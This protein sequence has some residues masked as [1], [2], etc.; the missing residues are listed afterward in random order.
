M[1]TQIQIRRDTTAGWAD[2][3][4]ILAEGELGLDTD[5]NTIKIGNGTASWSELAFYTASG[6]IVP[7]PDFLTYGQGRSHLATLNTNFGWNS[8]GLW[9]GPAVGGPSSE[10]YPVFTDFTLAETDK[11]VVS[12]NVSV[13]SFCSD[14]GVCVYLD[15]TIPNW[16][17]GI[18]DTRIAAQFNCPNPQIYGLTID[19]QSEASGDEVPNPGIYRVVFTYDPTAETEKVIFQYFNG[20]TELTR[21][22]LNEALPTGNYRIGF[23][24]D[25]NI[26][27]DGQSPY[28]TYISDLDINI[29][30]EE[31]IYTDTLQ[32]G[33]SRGSLDIADFVFAYNSGDGQ[34]TMTIHNHDMIIRTTRDNAEDADIS[35]NSADDIWITANDLVEIVSNTSEIAFIADSNTNGYQWSFGANGTTKFPNQSSNQRTGTGEVLKFSNSS[36]QSII[37]GPAPTSDIPTAQRLVVA[38][39][40]GFDGTDFDGEGGDIYLW[41]GRGGGTTGDGGDIKIDGGNGGSETGNGGYVKVRGGDSQGSTGGFVEIC[42]GDSYSASGGNVTIVAGNNNSVSEAVGGSVNIYGGG[43]ADS[44]SGGRNSVE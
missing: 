41:A 14:M 11:V 39:Q 30:N 9:F 37:T 44:T 16:A 27:E 25:N 43:S 12:F 10:S 21:L 38:G 8:E 1:A 28:R 40:D 32:A 26:D 15:G 20:Q 17:W 34:S 7:L 22:T 13:D 4:P 31:T 33:N 3:D 18:D 29:N 5:L 6:T 24:A 19:E 36:S 23:A 2:A 42:A 35:L